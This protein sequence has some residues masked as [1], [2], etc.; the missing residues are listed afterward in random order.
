MIDFRSDNT[1]PPAQTIVDRLSP[2]LSQVNPPMQR[3]ILP[4]VNLFKH[5]KLRSG[6]KT[7]HLSKGGDP[8]MPKATPAF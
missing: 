2:L 8:F 5:F 3:T 7:R 6:K 4:S 1:C